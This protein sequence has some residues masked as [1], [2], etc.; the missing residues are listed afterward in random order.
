[1]KPCDHD[2]TTLIHVLACDDKPTHGGTRKGAGRKPTAKAPRN[3][4]V[5][6]L[7]LTDAEAAQLRERAASR[8][9]SVQEAIRTALRVD[10]LLD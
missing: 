3:V 9:L 1:M 2:P 4:A 10:G 7:L 6:P 8:S 5:G